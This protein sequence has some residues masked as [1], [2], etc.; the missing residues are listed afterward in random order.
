MKQPDS[1][2]VPSGLYIMG[3]TDK[4]YV[5]RP[6]IS[7]LLH[8]LE[9]EKKSAEALRTV[10]KEDAEASLPKGQAGVG[11][12][13]AKPTKAPASSSTATGR[14]AAKTGNRGKGR[15]RGAA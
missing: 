4:K 12:L 5:V 13:L 7:Q 8:D 2:E 14:G 10:K 11:D 6:N 3:Q 1:E 15:G 9:L